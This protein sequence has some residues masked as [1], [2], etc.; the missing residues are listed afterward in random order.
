MPWLRAAEVPPATWIKTHPA[1]ALLAAV[2][3]G[4]V[5]ESGPHLVFVTLFAQGVL[6]FPAGSPAEFVGVEAANA[7]AGPALSG[8][9]MAAGA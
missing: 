1:W 9:P 5:P 3:I 7:T 8:A 2:L 6:P 4:V